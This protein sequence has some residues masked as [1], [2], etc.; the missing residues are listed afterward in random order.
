MWQQINVFS[1]TNTDGRLQIS[2]RQ[3]QNLYNWEIMILH[4]ASDHRAN[5]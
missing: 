3:Q 1:L 4:I 2:K 5:I